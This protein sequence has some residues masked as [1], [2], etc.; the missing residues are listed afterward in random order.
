MH[1]NLSRHPPPPTPQPRLGPSTLPLH[2]R[3]NHPVVA[4]CT[5]LPFLLRSATTHAPQPSRPLSTSTPHSLALT[6]LPSHCTYTPTILAA[7]LAAYI[8]VI[9]RPSRRCYS[10]FTL[11]SSIT[12][13]ALNPPRLPRPP[14]ALTPRPQQSFNLHSQPFKSH[15]PHRPIR[16]PATVPDPQTCR[17]NTPLVNYPEPP[18]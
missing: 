16:H 3:P 6:P 7:P 10:A 4:S 17:V 5:H 1:P 8:T 15:H 9:P 2:I 11:P 18:S 14:L 13:P 12:A